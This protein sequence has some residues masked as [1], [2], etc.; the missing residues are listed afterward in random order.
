MINSSCANGRLHEDKVAVPCGAQTYCPDTA[1]TR[2][3]WARVLHGYF[4]GS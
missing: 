1:I 4:S 2:G 3:K